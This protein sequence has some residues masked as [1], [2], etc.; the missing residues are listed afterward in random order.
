[1]GY[2]SATHLA[3]LNRDIQNWRADIERLELDGLTA[4]ANAVRG[5]IKSAER[6]VALLKQTPNT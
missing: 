5:W 2:D 4:K 6:L 3:D 1:M